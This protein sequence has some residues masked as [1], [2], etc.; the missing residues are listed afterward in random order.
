MDI[1]IIVFIWILSGGLASFLAKQKGRNPITWGI[2]GFL[3]G[4]VACYI[5]F[6]LP[7]KTLVSKEKPMT[8]S[9]DEGLIWY[10]LDKE[11]AQH[12]PMS[13]QKLLRHQKEISY[14]WNETMTE[15]Q[16]PS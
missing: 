15:W 14:V 3:G 4:L 1:T 8:S 6:I 10:Y 11:H 16:S 12:G 2:L 5:I 7:P 9:G 13:Y